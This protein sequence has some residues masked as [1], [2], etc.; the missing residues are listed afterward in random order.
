MTGIPANTDASDSFTQ[1]IVGDA[2]N[3]GLK[4]DKA[5]APFSIVS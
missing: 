3:S 2:N 4:L 1:K 5:G